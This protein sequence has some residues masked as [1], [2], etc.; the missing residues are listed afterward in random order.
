[1]EDCVC[2]NK[3]DG[4]SHGGLKTTDFVLSFEILRCD[5]LKFQISPSKSKTSENHKI[6]MMI[7]RC[8]QMTIVVDSEINTTTTNNNNTTT[9]NNEQTNERTNERTNVRVKPNKQAKTRTN[10]KQT[11]EQSNA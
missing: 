7:T 9:N 4:V 8:C 3:K 5:L 2:S 10:D 11:N 1:M 6:T